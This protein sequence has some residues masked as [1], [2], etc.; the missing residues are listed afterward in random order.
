M[1]SLAR[2]TLIGNAQTYLN[3]RAT[4]LQHFWL[5]ETVDLDLAQTPRSFGDLVVV[6]ASIPEQL[7]Q[8][9]VEKARAE[10]PHALI[11]R[12]DGFDSGPLAG[13][14]ANVDDEKGPGALVSACFELLTERGLESRPWPQVEEGGWVQ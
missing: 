1:E 10:K 2:V 8:F 9:W 5:V 12:I 4:V 14:D 11:V 7:R 3:V 6:C 13:A